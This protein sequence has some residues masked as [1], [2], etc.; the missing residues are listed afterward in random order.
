MSLSKRKSFE[1]FIRD[2]SLV[3]VEGSI[4][5]R[6]D[7]IFNIKMHPLLLNAPMIYKHKERSILSKV[8]SSYIDVAS[9]SCLP[10]LM[11]TPTYRCD[12]DRVASY[13]KKTI[14][15]D[16]VNFMFE[17]RD[18]YKSS[19]NIKIGGLIGCKNNAYKPEESLSY[20]QSIEYYSWQI[21]ELENAGV[22]FIIAQ[23]LPSIEEAKGIAKSISYSSCP[24]IISFVINRNGRLLDGTS[25]K[26]A[27]LDI[28]AC[29]NNLPVGFMLNCSHPTFL[30][31]HNE[32]TEIPDRLLGFLGNGSSMDH[33]E[34]D[35]ITNIQ[36]DSISDWA[37]YMSIIKK[38]FNMKIIGGCCG[39]GP[40]HLRNVIQLLEG[41]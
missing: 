15:K 12:F 26:D 7:H 28:D 21:K 32:P 36:S 8:Y 31:E 4:L 40:E 5:E 1:L 39:T 2:N 20:K 37:Y 24:Y 27:I 30:F 19:V 11:C 14:N 6:L 13:N 34:L 41:V 22:D 25:I 17:V 9:D 16:A 23:T 18:L 38:K 10:F 33:N 29:V 35:G 3:L